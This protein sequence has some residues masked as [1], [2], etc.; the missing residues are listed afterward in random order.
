M[1][2]V[3]ATREGLVGKKTATGHL[4]QADSWFVALPSTKALRRVVRL[5][6]DVQG[7]TLGD[8]SPLASEIYLTAPVLDVGPWNEHD[9]AYV[10]G[11]ARPQA[12][13]GIS[14]SGHGTNKAGIDL[15]D[16]VFKALGLKD[17]TFVWWE[18]I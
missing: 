6:L 5:R 3:L 4:I 18:L 16:A 8:G 11:D 2:R 15:S 14:V 17:N 12:E 7:A 9:D 13:S 1:K 10:F